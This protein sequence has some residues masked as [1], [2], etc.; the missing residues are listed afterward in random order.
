MSK[1]FQALLSGVFFTYF[2]DFFFFL[3]LK[4]NYFDSLNI[5]IFYNVLFADNQNTIVFF[6][7]TLIIGFT[8]IYINSTLFKVTLITTFFIVSASTNISLLGYIAGEK[9]FMTKNRT[10]KNQK[11]TFIGDIY[12]KGRDGI[13]F[14]DRELEKMIVLNYNELLKD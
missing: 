2:I 11:H 9:L 5:P 10:F 7:F 6:L 8:I 4:Q 1:L 3:G 14:Y 12:Y 13:F